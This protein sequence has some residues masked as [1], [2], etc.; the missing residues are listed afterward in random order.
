MHTHTHTFAHTKLPPRQYDAT[1]VPEFSH[2]LLCKNNCNSPVVNTGISITLTLILTYT[3]TGAVQNIMKLY[4]TRQCLTH[5]E[6]EV[7][8]TWRATLFQQQELFIHVSCYRLSNNKTI[9]SL[10]RTC[11]HDSSARYTGVLSYAPRHSCSSKRFK[12]KR[13]RTR[14]VLPIM[15]VPATGFIFSVPL[16]TLVPLCSS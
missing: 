1:T 10:L 11:H 8:Q 7:R 6:E 16:F 5:A 9:T 14:R 2:T 3:L 12:T 13:S 15:W 4:F